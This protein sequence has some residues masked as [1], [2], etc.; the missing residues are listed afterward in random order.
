MS[1]DYI[2]SNYYLCAD[3]PNARWDPRHIE[4]SRRGDVVT[5]RQ[6][7]SKRRRR[8]LASTLLASAKW[9]IAR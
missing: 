6:L 9:A 8:V 3:C 5:L 2:F 7:G 4:T 1:D